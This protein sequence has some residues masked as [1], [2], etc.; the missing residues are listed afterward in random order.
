MATNS[1]SSESEAEEIDALLTGCGCPDGGL[2]VIAA[3]GALS[4]RHFDF[5][6]IFTP[7]PSR[8]LMRNRRN[9]VANKSPL[10]SLFCKQP[11]RSAFL[12]R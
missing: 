7:K 3:N 1:P 10:L 12:I 9:S 11:H 5:L 2:G 6:I 4:R 8:T